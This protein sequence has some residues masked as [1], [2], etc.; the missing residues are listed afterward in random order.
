MKLPSITI[1]I[2][3]NDDAVDRNAPISEKD[4][5]IFSN[6]HSRTIGRKEENA[7]WGYE[8]D[9]PLRAGRPFGICAG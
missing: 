1:I 5:R 4:T 3:L 7:V 2:R 8:K 6:I 9:V